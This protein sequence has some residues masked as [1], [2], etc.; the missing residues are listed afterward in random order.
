MRPLVIVDCS[1][2]DLL[3][4]FAK[5]PDYRV[6]KHAVK[7]FFNSS[8]RWSA[9]RVRV[10]EEIGHYAGSGICAVPVIDAIHS[11]H[12]AQ[13]GLGGVARRSPVSDDFFRDI[14]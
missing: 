2:I 6:A 13:V 10:A 9:P 5:A 4:L 8:S 1:F 3:V 11:E 14:C 7:L 12:R